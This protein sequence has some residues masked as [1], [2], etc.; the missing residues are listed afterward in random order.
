MPKEYK[1]SILLLELSTFSVF[2]GRAWQ[3]ILWDAPYRELFWD[4]NWMQGIVETL[5]PFT[6]EEYVTSPQVDMFIQGFNTVIGILYLLCA[7]ASFFIKKIPQLKWLLWAGAASLV[8]LAFTYLKDHF[9]HTGQFFEYTLQFG[10]PL[11]LTAAVLKGKISDQL[12][13]WMKIAVALTF[14]CHGLYA[15][16]YYPRPGYYTEMTMNILGLDNDSAVTLLK[17]AGILDFVVAAGIFFPGKYARIVLAYAIC[18]G[19]LT[20]AAR[21]VGNFFWQFPLDSLSQ[22]V[23]EAVYR[24]PHFL[25]PLLLFF[26]LR[27][28]VASLQPSTVK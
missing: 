24:A 16:G 4:A 9:F 1:R 28:T 10:S 8:F 22:W 19:F 11:M 12:I 27:K 3:H 25:I 23:H 2:I 21:I 15:I 14:A 13:Y 6:W 7:V 5:T 20:A 26:H 17:I 18:W